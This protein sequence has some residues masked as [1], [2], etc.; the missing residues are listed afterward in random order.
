MK[1][2]LC[3]PDLR[4][5]GG[6]SSLVRTSLESPVFAEDEL[7]LFRVSTG[8]GK[9]RKAGYA[10]A[11]P[12]RLW[13]A[14]AAGYRPDVGHVHFGGMASVIREAGYAA[15]FEAFGIPWVAHT[16]APL[17]LIRPA[18]RSPVYRHIIERV[19]SRADA[20]LAVTAALEP[21]LRVWTGGRVPIRTVY[22]P[23]DPSALPEPSGLQGPPELLFLG[24][25]VRDKGVYDL[26]EVAQRVRDAVPDVRFTLGGDGPEMEAVRAAVA[27]AGVVDFVATP[28][29]IGG[30]E[31]RAAF[32]RATVF[33]LPSYNEGFPVCIIEAMAVGLPVVSTDVWGIPE[34]VLHG[35]T[36]V[37]HAP[38][39][40]DALAAA[41]IELLGDRARARAMGAAGR[42][43]ALTVF[44]RDALMKQ[45]R[46]VW[47]E[48]SG[49]GNP[50]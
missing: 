29:W 9:L 14:L 22:N 24:M 45:T 2:A 35:E 10:A 43:R 46:D 6:I 30:A 48:L 36:G 4:T 5:V 17:N 16:H 21:Q 39:D 15:A 28:G 33:S 20:I 37:I 47:V 18:E 27:A 13:A 38:G 34:A 31:L 32:E 3:T 8:G 40:Q 12:A 19:L 26:I 50:Y 23:V 41:L 7:R 1:V 42:E 11:G 25:M 49:G 44:D